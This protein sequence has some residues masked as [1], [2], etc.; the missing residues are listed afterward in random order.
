MAEETVVLVVQVRQLGGWADCLKRNTGLEETFPCTFMNLI[1]QIGSC[2][3]LRRLL[4]HLDVLAKFV[5]IKYAL[6]GCC[7]NQHVGLP[8]ATFGPRLPCVAHLKPDNTAH[9]GH[10][11]LLGS[12]AED[13]R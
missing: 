1:K 5:S 12:I 10:P 11:L 9:V 4:P 13:F 3:S 8:L 2:T 7:K 6:P